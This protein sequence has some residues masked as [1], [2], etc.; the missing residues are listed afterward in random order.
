MAARK[1]KKKTARRATPKPTTGDMIDQLYK[2][3]EKRLELKATLEVASKEEKELAQKIIG[4][5][6]E[7]RLEGAKGGIANFG[8][9]HKRRVKPRM[10]AGGKPDWKKTFEWIGKNKAWD[11]LHKRLADTAVLDR[12]DN[13][14][15]VPVTV[16]TYTDYSLTKIS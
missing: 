14:V 5:L 1:T 9:L 6:N 3:R 15:K 4:Q 7:S 2:M 16:E 12:L 13:G 8:K 11:M 10:G